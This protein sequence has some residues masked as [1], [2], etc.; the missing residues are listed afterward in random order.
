VSAQRLAQP[1]W[2]PS[3]AARTPQLDSTLLAAL[4]RA[5]LLEELGLG[6]EAERE[7]DW[8]TTEAQRS[9]EATVAAA[10]AFQ[11]RGMTSRAIRLANRALWA[12]ASRD[13]YLFRV[14][15]PVGYESTLTRQAARHGLD[16]ALVA[17]LIRQES[18]F[19]PRATSV[20]GARGLMQIMPNVGRQLARSA[21]YPFWDAALLYQP[22]V[23]L[24]LGTEHLAGLLDDYKDVRH[25]LAAYNAGS[26]RAKRWL[27][28]PG[29]DDPEVFIERIPFTETRGYVRVIL[30]N[31]EMYRTLY[32]W[33]ESPSE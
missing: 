25:A 21:D 17:A 27:T 20:A 1:G 10:H 8:V 2:S 24:E 29:T 23:S 6:A 22:D 7:Y 16:P 15:Y 19:E 4:K 9:T 31:R 30:R 11:E 26:S 12:G 5:K 3:A 14:L 28:K 13:E 18:S 32:G 33:Q